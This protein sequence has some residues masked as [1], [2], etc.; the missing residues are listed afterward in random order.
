MIKMKYDMLN[1][2]KVVELG[3]I[4]SA[5]Y[6]SK[7]L[8]DLG[9]EV[10]KIE[11]GDGDPYRQLPPKIGNESVWFANFNEGKRFLK[12]PDLK[13]WASNVDVMEALKTADILIENFRPGVLSKFG[14]DFVSIKKLNPKIIYVSISAFGQEGSLAEK[15]GFDIVVQ[16]RAGYLIDYYNEKEIIHNPHVY[17]SDYASGLFAAFLATAALL[18]KERK[19]VHIDISMFD[20]LVNWSSIFYAIT[21]HDKTFGQL[22]FKMDPVAYP[23]GV[24]KTKDGKRLVI[25]VVGPNMVKR[26]FEAFKEE[27]VKEK[28]NVED[29]LSPL[30]FKELHKKV[31]K[32]IRRKSFDKIKETLDRY[33]LPWEEVKSGT[34]LINDHYLIERKLFKDII[35][36]SGAIR[37]ARTPINIKL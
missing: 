12:I 20:I 28:L 37:V 11:A 36:Q 4:L 25:A 32:V 5:P 7:L 13:D 1:G 8:S 26:F 3:R 22:I 2:I 18:R 34:D 15:P 16:A 27:F 9:A 19:A 24:F 21:Y 23:Y 14:L 33:R 29:F 31:A 17:I 35:T 10:I 30:K 6:A